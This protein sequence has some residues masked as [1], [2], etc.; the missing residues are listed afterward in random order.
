L[1]NPFKFAVQ[2]GTGTIFINDPG[3]DSWEEINEGAWGANYGWPVHEGVAKDP[4]YVDPIFAYGPEPSP[5]GCAM[6]ITGGA[7]YNPTPLQFPSEF[8]G[9]YFFADYCHDWIRKLDAS[10]GG[11]SDFASGIDKPIDLEVSEE[12]EL[13]YL[14]RG[15]TGLVGKISYLAK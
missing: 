4:P 8:E 14:S 3:E 7:F 13:Y 2:P 10:T 5:T 12:G 9:D 1:R 6:A 15:S 11:A